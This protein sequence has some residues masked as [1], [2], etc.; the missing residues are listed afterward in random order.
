MAFK[1]EEKVKLV[2][3]LM[4]STGDVTYLED[5]LTRLGYSGDWFTH[6]LPVG[7]IIEI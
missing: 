7:E 6:R 5:T 2:L 4:H 3:F 1:R